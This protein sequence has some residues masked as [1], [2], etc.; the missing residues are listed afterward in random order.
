MLAHTL[1]GF[2]LVWT[3]GWAGSFAGCFSGVTFGANAGRWSMIGSGLQCSGSSADSQAAPNARPVNV[4]FASKAAGRRIRLSTH[5]VCVGRCRTCGILCDEL[6]NVSPFI[7]V[8]VH[9]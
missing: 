7:T 8:L 9:N 4:S 3:V 6:Q 1:R 2:G 5:E